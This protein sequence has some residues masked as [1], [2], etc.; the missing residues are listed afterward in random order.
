LL[1]FA[2]AVFF[3][4]GTPGPG[5]LTTAGV[6]SGFGWGA[7]LRF[8]GGLFCGTN[9]VALIVVSGLWAIVTAE[10]AV[11]TVLAIA[12]LAYFGW[13]A[14]K[15]ALAGGGRVAFIEAR[16]APGFV[17]GLALQF[18]NPKAYAVNTYLF[19]D[20]A[21]YPGNLGLEVLVKLAIINAIW[22]PIH[23]GWL[24]TGLTLRRL[25]LPPRAQRAINVGMAL[26]LIAVVLLAAFA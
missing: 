2:A 4:I 24:G 12:S 1:T 6:G 25:H 17:N 21:F 8:V 11:R 20:F 22:V 7:G 9:G 10:P 19:T 16:R 5:V 14:A 18:I 23:L 13:L 3:L 26:S 15:I